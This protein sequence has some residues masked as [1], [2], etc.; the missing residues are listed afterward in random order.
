MDKAGISQSVKV[1]TGDSDRAV[2][3]VSND[4]TLRELVLGTV[5]G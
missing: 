2:V 1:E 5:F 4:M 3:M